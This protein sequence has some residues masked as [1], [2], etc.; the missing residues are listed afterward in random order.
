LKFWLGVT[1]NAWFEFLR[2]EQP[3]EVNFW[4]PSGKAPFVGLAPGAPFLFKLKSPYN[5][6]A[7]GGFFVKFSVLPLSMAWDAFGRKN[8]AASREA[9]EGMIKRLAPDPRVRDPE[10]GCTILSMPFFWPDNQWIDAP[11][12][13]RGNIVRGRYYESTVDEGAILWD[14]VEAREVPFE[15]MGEQSAQY[16]SPVLVKP[17]LGQGA[18]RVVVMDAYQRRCAIT[19]EHTLPVLEA[20][21]ILPFSERGPH[22]VRNGLLLRSDFHKLFDIGLVTVT[23][24]LHIEVSSRIRE[25]WFNGKAYYRLHGQRLAN[26]PDDPRDHPDVGLLRWH[27][28]NRFQG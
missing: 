25:E 20:A 7:G 16:G 1:D 6:V 24:A 11:A 23:P 26:L 2:R 5:H 15:A 17:R 4:Q 27:N 3:D 10:I 8:G 9:F 18:F 13:W 21:H 14:R 19:G 28:E 12:G 22:D